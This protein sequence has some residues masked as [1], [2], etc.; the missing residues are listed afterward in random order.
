MSD[1]SNPDRHFAHQW[2]DGPDDYEWCSGSGDEEP[3]TPEE[4]ESYEAAENAEELFERGGY[5]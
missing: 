4:I 3:L 5:G 2:R 1:C